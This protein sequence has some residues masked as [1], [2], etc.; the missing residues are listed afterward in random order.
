MGNSQKGLKNKVRGFFGRGQQPNSHIGKV[1][2]CPN[3]SA[4]F[5]ENTT[6]QAV[7]AFLTQYNN[8]LEAC[9]VSE[10]S[11]LSEPES[12]APIQPPVQLMQLHEGDY[13]FE[14]VAKW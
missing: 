7:P 14:K 8:H 1:S 4:K 10:P 9:L 12:E 3:C 2:E 5:D 13:I 11:G 6:Y